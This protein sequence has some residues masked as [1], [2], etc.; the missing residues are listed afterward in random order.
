MGN[1]SWVELTVVLLVLATIFVPRIRQRVVQSIR[2]F[3]WG[4]RKGVRDND[5]GIRVREVTERRG[6]A[7]ARQAH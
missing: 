6:D 4:V 5:A 2:A 3:G 1:V 7:D